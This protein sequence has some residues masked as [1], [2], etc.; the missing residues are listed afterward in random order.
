[1]Q[2]GSDIERVYRYH[3][4]TK[5]D[6]DRF[7]PS[8]GYLDWASQP[9]PFRSFDGA[10]VFSFAPGADVAPVTYA[11]LFEPGSVDPLPLT[12]ATIGVFL[13]HALGLSA[14]K[15]Y[16]GVRWSLRVNPSSGN[17]HPT[18]G[19][20][21]T[22]PLADFAA[23]PGV[24]QANYSSTNTTWSALGTQP[25]NGQGAPYY[26]RYTLDVLGP[27][28]SAFARFSVEIL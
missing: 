19:Y 24:W 26:L 18:E 12:A 10:P 9:R 5:H 13:R 6:F 3:D 4:G 16:R 17:L 15:A 8:L 27:C 2:P 21:V 14:W 11:R 1:M 22:G 7:A 20:I 25:T 23:T 28:K